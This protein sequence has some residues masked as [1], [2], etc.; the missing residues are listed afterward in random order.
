MEKI[1][2]TS[3]EQ[4]FSLIQKAIASS[5]QSM[6]PIEPPKEIG[7][8]ELAM[9]ITGLSKSRIYALSKAN[10]IPKLPGGSRLLRFSRTDLI[11]WMRN[12]KPT[13]LV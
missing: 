10:K 3:E 2:I 5:I 13:H 4:L 1:Y 8:I 6:Q 11:E 7:G 12:N 9:E